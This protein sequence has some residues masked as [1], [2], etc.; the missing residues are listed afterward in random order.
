MPVPSGGER[1]PILIRGGYVVPGANRPHLDG[2]DILIDDGRIAAIGPGLAQSEAVARRNPRVIDATK[3]I[4]IPGFINAH[5]HSN[6]SFCQGFWDALPLEVW[7]LHAYPPFSLTP[8]PERTHYLAAGGA[9]RAD[10]RPADRRAPR[11]PRRAHGAFHAQPRDLAHRSRDRDHR[12]PRRLD[13]PQSAVEPQA[14]LRNSA[15]CAS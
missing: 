10:V 6:E 15:G 3:R 4:V 11:H 8:L 1:R 7:I 2:A 9:G 14:R 13:Q 12:R 5:T